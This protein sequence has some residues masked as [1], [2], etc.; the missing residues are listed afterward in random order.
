MAS[1]LITMARSHISKSLRHDDNR[2]ADKSISITKVSSYEKYYAYAMSM[3]NEY[4]KR[5]EL[6]FKLI[7]ASESFYLS[8]YCYVCGQKTQFYTDFQYSFVAEDG[9]RLPNWRERLVCLGCRLNNR[10]RASIQIFEQEC[11]PEIKDAIYITE[12][13]T[14]LFKWLEKRYKNV[15]GSEYLGDSIPTGCKNESGIRNESVLDLSFEDSQ[16]DYILCFDVFEH[17]PNY[18]RAFL[19]CFRCLRPRGALLF[20]VPFNLNSQSNIVRARVKS[21]GVVEHYLDPEYHGDPLKPDGCLCYYHF[22]WE[23]LTE[24]REAGF[25]EVSCCF[26]WSKELGYM[27]GDQFIFIARK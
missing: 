12:Q 5:K 17:V 8:G 11:K 19:E 20:S 10:M 2:V 18:Q 9:V 15:V 24:M 3:K 16:F 4:L 22:G 26:Y 13:T 25:A 6:E 7:K 27:G 1:N 21:N 14:P 23:T